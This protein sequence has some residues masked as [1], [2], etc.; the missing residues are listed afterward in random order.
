MLL[1]I[2]TM[3]TTGIKSSSSMVQPCNIPL[4][5]KA[6]SL[7]TTHPSRQQLY[8]IDY[9]NEQNPTLCALRK[10]VCSRV[11]HYFFIP[12][13][14]PASCGLLAL[15]ELGVPPS[16]NV[17]VYLG[18][19]PLNTDCATTDRERAQQHRINNCLGFLFVIRQ[20]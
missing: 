20:V 10:D 2:I 17:L 3:H 19:T 8:L 9:G 18:Y 6:H 5:R 15:V 16:Y 13:Y 7:T 12:N 11:C 14:R 4:V 1:R